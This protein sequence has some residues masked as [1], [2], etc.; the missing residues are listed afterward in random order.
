MEEVAMVNQATVL[1]Q[2]INT[3]AYP[4][5]NIAIDPSRMRTEYEAVVAQ[6]SWRQQNLYMNPGW[7]GIAL[8]S[9]SGRSD[10]LTLVRHTPVQRTP[11]GVL[12][13]YI[14]E[15]VLPQFGARWLRVAFY[16]LEAGKRI[17]EH[18]DLVHDGF[19]RVTVRIHLPVVTNEQVLM[20]VD[21]RAYYFAP[22]TAWYF[23][24]TARHKVEN[25]SNEDRIHLMADFLFERALC[26]RLRTPTNQDRVRFAWMSARYYMTGLVKPTYSRA[27]RLRH[28]LLAR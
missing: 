3:L 17:G 19:H 15:E 11:A 1:T 10:D 9:L 25:N 26:E 12:C 22:G 18:R 16:K 28:R 24:P 8:F 13:P 14:C 2:G 23:D 21:R 20:Y 5:E 7:E 27:R 4:I 6:S